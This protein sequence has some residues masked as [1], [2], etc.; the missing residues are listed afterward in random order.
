MDVDEFDLRY[1]LKSEKSSLDFGANYRKT[2][3][4][5]IGVTT[6][7]D[8]GSWGIS[9]PRDIETFA[10]G[11]MEAF[12]MSCRFDDFLSARRRSP[13]AAMPRICSG[14]SRRRIRATR[15]ASVP[16]RTRST[17]TSSR[18]MRS[19]VCRASCWDAMSASPVV[20]VMRRLRS[21]R[22]RRSRCRLESA[23]QPITTSSSTTAQRLDGR[24]RQRQTTTTSC[25][26]S[27][28]RWT[29]RTS[30]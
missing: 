9:N 28:S 21:R 6:Q 7:Q 12:C 29:S 17:R 30:S 15:S 3:V 25:R 2:S 19:S 11:V 22:S 18:S 20:S 14:R 5:V 16:T 1:S 26:T 24:D 27:T 4:E 13:S 10:P 8:L 23:G